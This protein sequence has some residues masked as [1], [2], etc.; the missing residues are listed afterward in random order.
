MVVT[1]HFSLQRAGI[2]FRRLA[3]NSRARVPPRYVRHSQPQRS[4]IAAALGF[5]YSGRLYLIE[6]EI[7]EPRMASA[8]SSSEEKTGSSVIPPPV[9]ARTQIFTRS[10]KR[11]KLRGS[12]RMPISP[13]CL[14]NFA[15]HHSRVLQSAPA[16][17]QAVRRHASLITRRP[18][19]ALAM[20]ST[21]FANRLRN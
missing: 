13:I 11:P 9:R 15:N 21:S 2:T 19:L 1:G 18:S 12:N 17:E 5:L 8:P 20:S 14:P 10:W 4:S 3:L 6:R 16:G 7:N